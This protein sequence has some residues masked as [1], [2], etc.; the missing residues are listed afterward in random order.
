MTSAASGFTSG[1]QRFSGHA[2][3]NRLPTSHFVTSL[4]GICQSQVLGSPL[5]TGVPSGWEE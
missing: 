1:M 2:G 5:T 4:Y 3:L